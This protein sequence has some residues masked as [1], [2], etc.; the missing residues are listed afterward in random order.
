MDRR[1]AIGDIHGCLNKLDELISKIDPRREDTFIFLGDY[2]D[3]GDHSKEVV[4]YLVDLSKEVDCVFLRGNHE[5]M[6]FEYLE[7]GTNEGIFFANGGRRTVES[8]LGSLDGITNDQVARA[9]PESH[10]DF[11]AG[12]AWYYE[13]D[14]YIY[15]HAGVKSSIPIAS[16]DRHDLLWVR[17]EFIFSPT[18]L[19]KKVIFGHTPF[20]RPMVKPD[21]IGID[22]G[23]VYGGVLTAVELPQ[24]TFI[25]N[26]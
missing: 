5:D 21:K 7:Y 12:L 3:R 4:E 16:Q 23:A 20:W 24:E 1:F 9:L 26:L 18:G 19:A 8:Y 2:L 10:R 13:D 15:V 11:F 25:Q 14:H 22:T 6:F 17:D